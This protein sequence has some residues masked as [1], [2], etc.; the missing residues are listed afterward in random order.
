MSKNSISNISLS[1]KNEVI[2]EIIDFYNIAEDFV[3]VIDKIDNPILKNSYVLAV[4][5]F[6]DNLDIECKIIYKE[7]S[8]L[9]T[10]NKV[11]KK[12]AKKI[13]DALCNI[14]NISNDA[15]NRLKQLS[16]DN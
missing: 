3:T 1:D 9:T 14:R 15:I 2:S 8:E 5:D 16:F 6:I 11:S 4:D 12:S 7:Y 13:A 10:K